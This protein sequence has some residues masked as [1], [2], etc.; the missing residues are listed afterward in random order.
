V[1]L[2]AENSPKEDFFESNLSESSLVQN[3]AKENSMLYTIT[4]EG[5]IRLHRDLSKWR[6]PVGKN[7]YYETAPSP[8]EN[9]QEK[10]F[11]ALIARS[12][13]E[14]SLDQESAIAVKSMKKQEYLDGLAG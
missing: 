10:E 2:K 7:E 9:A 1:N 5:K 6:K 3:K 12:T 13:K 14:L 4:P 11:A 8:H